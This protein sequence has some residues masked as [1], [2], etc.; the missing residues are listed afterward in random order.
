MLPDDEIQAANTLL[1]ALMDGVAILEQAAQ[2]A[3][4]LQAQGTKLEETIQKYWN[5]L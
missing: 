2:A 1:Q 3:A 5:M 4:P